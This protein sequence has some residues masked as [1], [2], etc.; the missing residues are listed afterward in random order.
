MLVIARVPRKVGDRRPP[1]SKEEEAPGA[2]PRRCALDCRRR[3]GLLG[4]A[5][6]AIRVAALSRRMPRP[7]IVAVPVLHFLLSSLAVASATP[8][9]AA[10][11][12]IPVPAT[13]TALA[14]PER[15][16]GRLEPCERPGIEGAVYCGRYEVFEDREAG[17]GRKIALN[18]LVLPATAEEP[19]RDAVT[20]LAGGGVAPA[21]EFAP[22]LARALDRVRKR[23]DV[24]L[25]DQRGTGA[26]NPLDCAVPNELA[27]PNGFSERYVEALRACRDTLS[28]RANLRLYTT[29]LAMDDLDEVRAWLGY[30][31]L[32][33]WGVSY[34]TK[35]AQVFLRRHPE[36]VRAAVL[37]GVAPLNRSMWPTLR[38]AGERAFR[39]L[40][41]RCAADSACG[42]AFP[43]LEREFEA[44]LERLDEA[45]VVVDIPEF[46]APEFARLTL[47]GRTLVELIVGA[48]GSM[49][50]ARQVPLLVDRASRGDHAALAALAP[51]GRSPVPAGV[52]HCI[53]CS[54][55]IARLDS[56]DLAAPA[57]ATPFDDGSWLERE[58]AACA[59]WPRGPV[60]NEFWEPVRS[61]VPVLILTG[62]EDFITPPEYG[63]RVAAFLTNARHIVLPERSHNDVD[64]CLVGLIQQ[65]VVE[66]DANRL[67][68]GCVE[69]T[70]PLQFAI[71]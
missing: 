60:P 22:F 26:S 49:R 56:A 57:I 32:T 1:R 71:E 42:A 58:R 46:R 59:V 64:P 2:A 40:L 55:E 34:G 48:L 9:V 28:A 47:S 30:E 44:L 51:R 33:L 70:P 8:R 53:A 65:F 68:L 36:R 69:E 54:E 6:V 14:V 11:E 19:E 15:F 3:A 43:D 25:M 39:R 38:P 35:A 37:H 63:D 7:T 4:S 45:P 66:P 24:L 67:D 61:G 18:V 62:A 31:R 12:R 21:T 27:D 52:Y 23:R 29:S 16:R 13:G 20:F 41:E 50:E 17:S 10:D 5:T